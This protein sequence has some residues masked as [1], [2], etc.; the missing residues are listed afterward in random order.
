ML[1]SFFKGTGW[2]IMIIGLLSS[3]IYWR[4]GI[5]AESNLPSS[6]AISPLISS[7]FLAMLFFAIGKGLEY[8]KRCADATEK[9]QNE[10]LKQ[11]N[12][13]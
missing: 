11:K 13:P 9:I 1:S 2:A 3:F 4:S 6:L 7:I 5:L 12:Q 8:L 10:L